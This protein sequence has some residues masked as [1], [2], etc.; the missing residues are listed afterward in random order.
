MAAH[1][2]SEMGVFHDLYQ[3]QRIANLRARLNEYTPAGINAGVILRKLGGVMKDDITRNTFGA[4]KHFSS[5]AD[6][7][8]S[9]AARRRLE[10][11][12]CDPSPLSA[13]VR[14]G[15]DRSLRRARSAMALSRCSRSARP[16]RRALPISR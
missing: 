9:G 7:A 3:P 15:P 4:L 10:R 8:G 14:G 2:E 13:Q 11:A 5:C 1:D 16:Q 6:A 12:G